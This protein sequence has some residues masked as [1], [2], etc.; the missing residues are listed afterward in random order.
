MCGCRG[1]FQLGD[2]PMCMLRMKLH[3]AGDTT[4]RQAVLFG[5]GA[6]GVGAVAPLLRAETMAVLNAVQHELVM[7][8]QHSA[9][10]NPVSFR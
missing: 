10:L 8:L 5:D 6:G 9:G 1:V 4:V 2:A 7:S 3:Q